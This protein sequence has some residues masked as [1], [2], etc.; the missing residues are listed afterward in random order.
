MVKASSMV[1]ATPG[2]HQWL[3]WLCGPV[4]SQYEISTSLLLTRILQ[5]SVWHH[6]RFGRNA[7]LGEVEIPMDS[8]DFENQLEECLPLHGKV[9]TL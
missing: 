8:W 5:F 3:T 4:S 1:L 2:S 6:D 7:F 9:W